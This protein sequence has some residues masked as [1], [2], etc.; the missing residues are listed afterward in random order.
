[1]K[2]EIEQLIKN[3]E[4]N[5]L[6]YDGVWCKKGRE[7]KCDSF[8]MNDLIEIV[9]E[10]YK[11]GFIDGGSEGAEQF[12]GCSGNLDEGFIVDSSILK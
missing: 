11:K 10:A 5:L 9:E 1:M 12:G 3:I 8:I 6:E 4:A 7:G 2:K